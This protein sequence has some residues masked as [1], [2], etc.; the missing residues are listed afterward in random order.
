MAIFLNEKGDP[1][2]IEEVLPNKN[3][4]YS[5]DGEPLPFDIANKTLLELR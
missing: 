1:G 4:V 5:L 3:S 2:T